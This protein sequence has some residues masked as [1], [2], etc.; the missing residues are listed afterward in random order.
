MR[1]AAPNVDAYLA[2]FPTETK[3]KLNELRNLIRKLAP[4]AEET[5]SYAIPTYK[6]NGP[7]VHFAGYKN[8][9]GFY[10]GAGGIKEFSDE[11]LAYKTSK[12]TVQFPIDVKLPK[13][14]ITKIVKFRIKQNL[15]K[16]KK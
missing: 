11:L 14:L 8:H 10:P 3:A 16:N 15:E 2:D 9:I 12:G 5:I 4:Q 7:L 1:T 6:L 13:A